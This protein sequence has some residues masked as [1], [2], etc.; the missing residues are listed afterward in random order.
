MVKHHPL[1]WFQAGLD[2]LACV[3]Q[4]P[5]FRRYRLASLQ[6][7]SKLQMQTCQAGNFLM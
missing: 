6:P 1:G 7:Q 2:N 5:A 3:T 4:H